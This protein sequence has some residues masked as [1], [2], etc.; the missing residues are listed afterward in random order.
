MSVKRGMV[1]MA[2]HEGEKRKGERARAGKP[3]LDTFPLNCHIFWIHKGLFLSGGSKG[4]MV[5]LG[6]PDPKTA[7]EGS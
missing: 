6:F 1:E 4:Q 5:N 7:A 2:D 3:R